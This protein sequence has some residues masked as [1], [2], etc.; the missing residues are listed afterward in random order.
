MAIHRENPRCPYCLKVIAKAI[1]KDQ[2]AVPSNMR[3]FGDTFERWEYEDHRCKEGDKATEEI[4]KLF[5][6]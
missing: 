1:Y 3:I 5:E 2:S 6:Q 4:N